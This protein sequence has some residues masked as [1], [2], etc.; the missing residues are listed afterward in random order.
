MRWVIWEI[1]DFD[2]YFLS[3]F[4]FLIV[5]CIAFCPCECAYVV[6]VGVGKVCLVCMARWAYTNICTYTFGIPVYQIFNGRK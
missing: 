2:V 1:D 4:D 6:Y 3:L 5:V